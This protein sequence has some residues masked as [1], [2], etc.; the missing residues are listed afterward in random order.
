MTAYH[1][2]VLTGLTGLKPGSD[3]TGPG[4]APLNKALL[5]SEQDTGVDLA[6]HGPDAPAQQQAAPAVVREGDGAGEDGG[7][8]GGDRKGGGEQHW[9]GEGGERRGA[10][11]GWRR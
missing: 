11:V 2:H 4:A 8:S 9:G 3:R 1:L 5:R 10:G 7:G 6:P